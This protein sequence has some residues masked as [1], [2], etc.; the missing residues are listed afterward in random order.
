[1]PRSIPSLLP[2][3]RI[4]RT[5]NIVIALLH[6]SQARA[7]G[8]PCSALFFNIQLGNLNRVAIQ[9]RGNSMSGSDSQNAQGAGEDDIGQRLLPCA[10]TNKVQCL[11][12]EA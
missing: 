2:A 12:A 7:C 9:M 6:D 1:M 8:G 4:L 11:Q 5:S 10:C 3:W